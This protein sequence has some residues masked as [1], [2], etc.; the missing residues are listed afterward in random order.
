MTT[1]EDMPKRVTDPI[2]EQLALLMETNRK[3]SEIIESQAKTIEELRATIVELNA[4]LAW[5]KRKVFGK[6]SEKCNPI[7]N[8]DPMLPFDYGD[9]G[10]IEAEIEAARNKAAQIITPKPQVAGKTPRRNRIIMDDLPVVTVVIEPEDLDLG[11]YVKIGEEHTR[12]LEMKPGYLY[13]KDT[14]RP[15]YAIKDETEAV[16]NGKRMVVTAPL[17]LMPIYKGMP[18]ASMLAEILLQ[19]YEYHVPFYRQVKQPEHLGVKLSRNTLNG[20]FKPVCELLRPLY[21]ELKKKVLS[22]DYIQVDETTLPVIDH[23][24]HKA[25]KEYIWIVRAAV[26]RLLFFHYANG[27]RSQKVAVDLLKTFK[28][29]LQCDGY[30]A[31]DAFEN[32][33][34]VRLC[35]CLAHIRRHIESCRE[36][37]REYA[38]QGLKFIQDLYN[39]EYMAD[40]RQLSYEERAALRQRLAGPLLDAFELWLQNTYPKVLKRSLMGKAIAYA[41][42]LI[43]RMRHYLYDGRI[44][45]DNNRA[46]N[47][48]RPM[49]LT[50][51]NMLFCGNQ[52]AA[53]NTAVICSLL[54]SCKECGVNPREWLNDVISKLPYYLTPK[55]EKKLTELLPDRWGGY[56]QSHDTLPTVTGMSMDNPRTVHRQTVHA[57]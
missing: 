3:Q 13:V 45:I 20:W 38:M 4:S 53:E 24:R 16:E 37:N 30:S 33:K 7:N 5:L 41:Y 34:D 14:V 40:E 26:P 49:V 21:L 52:Q 6:M 12:T 48:L 22:S 1:K 43:P 11:K 17:P 28:G 42:P 19:K 18:G 50:R 15:T 10:Q 31:Y 55:S 23:D 9:L 51:K 56:R 2:L 46:E 39:V 8:G 32:R 44:F 25:A 29:Y 54:G 47:A 57:T 27:S 36:E 35:G